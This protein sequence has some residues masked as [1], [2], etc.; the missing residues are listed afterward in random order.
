MSNYSLVLENNLLLEFEKFKR[1]MPVNIEMVENLLSYYKPKHIIN[2][3]QIEFLK[4]H[5]I[6]I[7]DDEKMLIM[8][9]G[10][11]NIKL[12]SLTKH[13]KYKI[14]LSTKKTNFPYVN[15]NGDTIKNVYSAKFEV[16]KSRDKALRHFKALINEAQ[17]ITIY[18]KY[19][20]Y[21]DFIF[22]YKKCC[23]K[24]LTINVFESKKLTEQNKND[25]KKLSSKINIGSIKEY[26]K[27]STHDRYLLV[28][29]K[30]S[31][32][33]EILLSSGFDNLM[34]TNKDFTYVLKEIQ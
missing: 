5:N 25:I 24:N 8:Q 22:F 29:Y 1:G 31:R 33:I 13:T 20:K 4:K 34:Q 27:N 21:N 15:I 9:S 18:D 32:K 23:N 17:T 6:N 3:R 26:N 12:D 10:Y 28:E 7:S 30:N 11:G 16:S 2:L 14:A 19:L